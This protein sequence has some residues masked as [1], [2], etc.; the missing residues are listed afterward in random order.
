MLDPEGVLGFCLVL[1]ISVQP[2][3]DL[4]KCPLGLIMQGLGL[5]QWLCVQRSSVLQL[6]FFQL[7]AQ[8][9]MFMSP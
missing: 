4:F 1:N 3:G 5:S 8:M 2:V 9:L 7:L 6:L